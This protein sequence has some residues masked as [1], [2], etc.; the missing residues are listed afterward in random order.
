VTHGGENLRLV[1]NGVSVLNRGYIF[2]S[3]RENKDKE[4]GL[5]IRVTNSIARV[6]E[7]AVRKATVSREGRRVRVGAPRGERHEGGI[8][9][10]AHYK[11]KKKSQ[12]TRRRRLGKRED[13][14]PHRLDP[15]L[16]L[17]EGERV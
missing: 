17:P 8:A 7:A 6:C 3:N 2:P 10:L 14:S 11:S 1:G 9:L 13:I 15:L 12:G 16:R 5:L 4:P